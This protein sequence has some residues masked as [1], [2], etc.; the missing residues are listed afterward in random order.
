MGEPQR[1][2]PDLL[3]PRG[4]RGRLFLREQAGDPGIVVAAEVGRARQN[5]R[6]DNRGFGPARADAVD[7]DPAT[8]ARAAA[9]YSSAATRDSPIRPN[10]A[11][12]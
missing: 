10:L 8:L 6:L 9:A 4:P 1:E 3:R 7:R 2:R 5:L 12:T 11:E